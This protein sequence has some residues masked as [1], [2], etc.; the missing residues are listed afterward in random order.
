MTTPMRCLEEKVVL[1]NA[2]AARLP[3]S[4]VLC[5]RSGFAEI[6]ARV[7]AAGWDYDEL[8]AKHMV[9]LTMPAQ[10]AELLAGIAAS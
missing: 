10:L 3:R 5:T 8:P 4:Y 7:R 6:A 9:M 2:A 1:R